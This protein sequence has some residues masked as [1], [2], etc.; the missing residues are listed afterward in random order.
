VNLCRSLDEWTLAIGKLTA[1]RIYLRG[2]LHRYVADFPLIPFSSGTGKRLVSA[3]LIIAETELAT[4]AAPLSQFCDRTCR[5]QNTQGST[6]MA[7]RLWSSANPTAKALLIGFII[8]LLLIP[9]SQLRSLVSERAAL[10]DEAYAK[11]AQGW[12]GTLTIGGPVLIVPME[13]TVIEGQISKIVRSE[14]YFLPDTLSV[15]AKLIQ[16]AQGRRVGLYEVPV[17]LAQIHL[18][19][20]FRSMAARLTARAG[21]TLMWNEARLRL[22]IS[23][24]RSL[25]E[26]SRAVF[27]DQPLTFAPSTSPLY[28]G[29]DARVSVTASTSAS[30]NIDLVA[31]GSRSFSILPLSATTNAHL[32]ADWPDPS[33]QGAFLPASHTIDAK[34]FDARWQVLE[35]NR[36]FGSSWVAGEL[37]DSRLLESAFGTT[38]FQS[39]DIY[40]RGERAMKYALVFIAL[41]FLSFFAWEQVSRVRMHA[42]QYLL[43]GLALSVFYLLLIA[44]SE[45]IAFA[46]AYLSAAAALVALLGVYVGSVMHRV[47]RG[48]TTA[49]LMSAVYSI[50]YVLVLSEDYALL[51]GAIVV[52]IALAAV[53]L[54]TRNID[55]SRAAEDNVP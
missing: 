12:G 40:Q 54:L 14:R 38:L 48:F 16:E 26:L 45:H 51:M 33:F 24:T 28:R 9:L 42:L 7:V 35:L 11:V 39:V 46:W 50:L 36:D 29:V 44:L 43:V 20:E 49:T 27:A 55:W 6:N 10:R 23:E 22:P 30:F 47:S 13:R 15:D 1:D 53:M 5:R 4:I 18:S 32:Q 19:G 34:G 25:R 8:L 21:E 41:T 17:Y 37:D 31:A 2:R 3:Y 52:F